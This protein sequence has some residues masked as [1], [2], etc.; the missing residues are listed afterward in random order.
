MIALFVGSKN[1]LRYL[2][3]PA[4]NNVTVHICN[5]S[6]G[7]HLAEVKRSFFYLEFT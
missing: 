5:T 7:T 2:N 1:L 4:V 3:F 6:Y